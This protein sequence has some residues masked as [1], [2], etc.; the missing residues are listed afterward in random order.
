MSMKPRSM[1]VGQRNVLRPNDSASLWNCTLSP[2]TFVWG[3]AKAIL[4]D[5]YPVLTG[6]T[7]E[8]SDILR[9]ALMRFGIGNWKDIMESGCLPGKTNAQL[10]LQ[11]QRLLGQQSTAGDFIFMIS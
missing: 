8:E 9:K 2:G 1:P 4:A 10:N 7:R 11:T 3:I 5:T 6:W